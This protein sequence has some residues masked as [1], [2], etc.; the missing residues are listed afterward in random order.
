[1]KV[2]FGEFVFDGE[3]CQV[4][5]NSTTVAL[6]PKS[7]QLLEMLIEERP[8][9]VSKKILIERLWPATAVAEENLK[10]R[11]REIRRALGD[12]A[13]EWI[14]T[15]R[16]FGYAFQAATSETRA[17]PP[18]RIYWLQR[19]SHG[20]AVTPGETYVGRDPRCGVWLDDASVSRKHARI[21]ISSNGV[22]LEDL[23]SKNGTAIGTKAISGAAELCDGDRIRIGSVRL[24]FRSSSLNESTESV[25]EARA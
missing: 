20:F 9:V 19:G 4:L 16:G 6:S 10:A 18:E 3:T 21:I 7:F 8:R 1:M 2:Q 23:G 14:R 25:P 11:I 22:T 12:D 13:R 17:L 5:R 15:A 24:T